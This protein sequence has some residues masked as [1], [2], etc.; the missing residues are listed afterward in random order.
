MLKHA[1]QYEEAV[2]MFEKAISLHTEKE[3]TVFFRGLGECYERMNQLDRA[4][5]AYEKNIAEFPESAAVRWDYVKLLEKIGTPE[6]LERAR[7]ILEEILKAA[8]APKVS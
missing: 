1:G 4:A 5:A 2:E 7:Q 6:L 3:S 8:A